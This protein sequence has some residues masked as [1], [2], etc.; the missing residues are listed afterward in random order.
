MLSPTFSPTFSPMVSPMFSADLAAAPI[1]DHPESGGAELAA[2]RLAPRA[3]PAP[4]S[5]GLRRLWP[6]LVGC[7]LVMLPW[8]ALLAAWVPAST[9]V[10]HWSTAWVGLDG[11]EAIGLM[12]TGWLLRRGDPRHC[13]AATATAAFLVTDAWF[14][15]TTASSGSGLR[16]AIAMA[17][18]GELPAAGLC[19]ALAIRSL[20]RQS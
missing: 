12:T 6:L 16:I 8:L 2:I 9:R 5:G 11:L 13:L 4:R 15:V 14:D 1:L 18:L 3:V 7:G 10:S 20:R 19:V 17:V